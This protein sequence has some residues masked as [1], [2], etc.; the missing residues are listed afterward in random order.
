MTGEESA[1]VEAEKKLVAFLEICRQG[2]PI[3]IMTHDHPDPDAMASAAG[4]QLLVKHCLKLKS[5]IVF[6]GLVERPENQA[7]KSYIRT[8]FSNIPPKLFTR[9]VTLILVDAQPGAGNHSM[10]EG[11]TP[12]AVFDHHPLRKETRDCAF[13]DVRPDTGACATMVAQYLKTAGVSMPRTL[14]TALCYAIVSE[15]RDLGREATEEDIETYLALLEQANLRKLSKI[16][17]SRVP[18]D[19]FLTLHAAVENAFVYRDIIGSCLGRVTR[20]DLA[21]QIADL[22]LT[23]ERMQ[24]SICSAA[25]KDKLYVSIRTTCLKARC[26]NIIG[27]ILGKSGS[28]GGHGMI[29]GGYL[30]IPANAKD[31]EIRAIE[32]EIMLRFIRHLAPPGVDNLPPFKPIPAPPPPPPVLPDPEII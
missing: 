31:D 32:K 11:Y 23:L 21:A 26:S 16:E 1:I 18:K 15:T 29:A 12:A 17:H 6:G 24:W 20:P 2:K 30:P 9:D 8:H 13:W 14:A 3:Y 10:P 5:R 25:F 19:Y 22:L 28:A 7:M 27:K 4:V